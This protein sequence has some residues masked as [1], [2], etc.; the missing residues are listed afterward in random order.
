MRRRF[1]RKAVLLPALVIAS[2][3]VGWQCHGLSQSQLYQSEME[4]GSRLRSSLSSQLKQ[5]DKLACL[6][7]QQDTARWELTEH[8]HR[9]ENAKEMLSESYG[10]STIG[11][12]R[13]DP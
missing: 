11:A 5:T 9:I 1:T 13:N 8:R 4:S 2:Y 7:N 3:A 10:V 12:G 6:Q